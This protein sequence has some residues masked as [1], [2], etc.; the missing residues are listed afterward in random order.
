MLLRAIIVLVHETI[1]IMNMC[2]LAIH[3]TAGYD[4]NTQSI[5]TYIPSYILSYFF[6]NINELG[7]SV[8]S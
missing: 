8:H 7:V 5:V 6:K 2:N 4:T 3:H 1:R